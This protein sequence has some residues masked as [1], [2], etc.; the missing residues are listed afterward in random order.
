MQVLDDRV[1]IAIPQ[2]VQMSVTVANVAAIYK[3][4]F[5]HK[6]IRV[7]FTGLY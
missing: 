3:L 5:I 6:S 2:G 4:R 7:Y 1:D